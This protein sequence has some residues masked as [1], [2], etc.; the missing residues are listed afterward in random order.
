VVR[1]REAIVADWLEERDEPGSWEASYRPLV[2]EGRRAVAEGTTSYTNGDSS[3]TCGR[4][5]S[6]RRTDAPSSWSGSWPGRGTDR[7]QE[8][9][10]RPSRRPPSLPSI[11]PSARKAPSRKSAWPR[12]HRPGVRVRIIAGEGIAP[13][14]GPAPPDRGGS[15]GGGVGAYL[16][17]RGVFFAARGGI[18]VASKGVHERANPPRGGGAKPRASHRKRRPGYRKGGLLRVPDRRSGARS[19]ARRGGSSR[20]GPTKGGPPVLRRGAV[21]FP[22]PRWGRP[23]S[24]RGQP[25]PLCFAARSAAP[26]P[27]WAERPSPR[28]SLGT[29]EG[30]APEA[31]AAGARI[32]RAGRE[33]PREPQGPPRPE[34]RRARGWALTCERNLRDALAAGDEAWLASGPRFR[35]GPRRRWPWPRRTWPRRRPG[36]AWGPAFRTRRR[37]GQAPPCSSPG[38]L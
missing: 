27:R 4:C 13:P 28:P 9:G 2:V 38:P 18:T 10:D 3:G 21:R 30:R 7:P 25:G 35:N 37:G 23:P 8:G 36:L 34:W 17:G 14:C 15:A 5:A 31:R 6:T 24:S 22:A 1:G 32:A 19:R 12:S 16:A 26:S 20:R 29:S 11:H 33:G